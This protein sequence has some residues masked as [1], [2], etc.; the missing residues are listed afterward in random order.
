[1]R[2]NR[3]DGKIYIGGENNYGY[4]TKNVSGSY[5]YTS[6]SVDSAGIGIITKIIFSD[7]LAWFYS[8]QTV[9]R[10]NL[11]TNT[12]ELR[13]KSKPDLPFTGMIVTPENTFVNVMNKGL[14][15]L[16]SDTL[17][18]IVTGYLTEQDEILFTLPYDQTRVLVGISRLKMTD[19]S[20][21]I[22]CRKELC[23][24]IQHMHFQLLMAVLL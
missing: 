12:L 21:A 3:S 22:F 19:I 10:F 15:R 18:P 7:S 6:L 20:K 24:A 4:M 13:L 1:M 2:K 11:K 5:D 17:F 16:E 14:H 8:E 23:W 9:D